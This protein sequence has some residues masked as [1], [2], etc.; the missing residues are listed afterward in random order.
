MADK[1]YPLA[2]IDSSL[3]TITALGVA[4]KEAV[5]LD[6]LTKDELNTILDRA[7]EIANALVDGKIVQK[8]AS[9]HISIHEPSAQDLSDIEASGQ[10]FPSVRKGKKTL[11]V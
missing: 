9:G 1:T 3:I 11:D 7:Q 10:P 4:L 8:E 5:A 2:H 6:T